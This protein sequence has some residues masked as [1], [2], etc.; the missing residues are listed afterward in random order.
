MVAAP[1]RAVHDHPAVLTASCR[2]TSENQGGC[3]LAGAVGEGEA[4]R[5]H[6]NEGECVGGD[7]LLQVE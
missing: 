4:R 5:F 1:C 3:C 2:P 7:A 6:E